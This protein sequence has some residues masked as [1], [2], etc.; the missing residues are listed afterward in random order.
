MTDGKDL[1]GFN[2]TKGYEPSPW[3]TESYTEEPAAAAAATD[4]TTQGK[5]GLGNNGK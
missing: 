2:E 4:V 3:P 1:T 5:S